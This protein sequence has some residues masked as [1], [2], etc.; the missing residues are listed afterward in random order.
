MLNEDKPIEK[1]YYTIGEVA[2]MFDLT[3]S[4]IRFWETEFDILMP[5]KNARGDRFFTKKDIENLRMIYYLLKER[6]YTIS[7]AKKKLK[8][9]KNEIQDRIDMIK[10]LEKIKSFLIEMKN[11]LDKRSDN[12]E[13]VTATTTI[14]ETELSEISNEPVA[15]I[16]ESPVTDL[17]Q[18]DA[19][20]GIVSITKE[21]V[22]NETVEEVKSEEEPLQKKSLPPISPDLF[23]SQPKKEKDIHTGHMPGDEDWFS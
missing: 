5:K 4:N 19:N 14:A 10:N 11:E 7:G 22:L 3:V 20:T 9:S 21:D 2:A 8:E 1:V 15:E 13:S 18:V 23:S 17:S 6:G 12:E 16:T